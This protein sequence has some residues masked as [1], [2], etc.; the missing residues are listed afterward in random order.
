MTSKKL[1]VEIVEYDKSYG[2]LEDIKK[3]FFNNYCDHMN[4][5]NFKGVYI[6]MAAKYGKS[7]YLLAIAPGILTFLALSWAMSMVTEYSNNAITLIS[8]FVSLANYHF[9]V[10]YLVKRMYSSHVGYGH[11]MLKNFSDIEEK[12]M[13]NGGTFLLALI[14]DPATQEKEI[15]GHLGF[16]KVETEEDMDDGYPVPAK[17]GN[18]EAIGVTSKYRGL[19]IGKKLLDKAISFAEAQDYDRLKLDVYHINTSAIELYKKYGFVEGK[20]FEWES[21]IGLTW[22]VMV[23]LLK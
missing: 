22:T 11:Y 19:G 9:L 8:V 14:E 6:S 4:L 3:I 23:K 20:T 7:L 10:S 17:V 18:L 5:N 15:V 16:L 13:K 21:L 2:S 1:Q 12:Y